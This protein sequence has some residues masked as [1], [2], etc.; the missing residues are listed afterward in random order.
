ML[1]ALRSDPL[2]RMLGHTTVTLV[3][4]TLTYFVLPL[5]FDWSSSWTWVRLAVCLVALTLLGLLM[6]KSIER[7]RR[8]QQVRYRRI[9][10]LLSALYVLVLA[11]ALFY[12]ALASKGG[13]FVGIEDRTD[14]LY[15][16]VTVVSTVGFGDIHASSRFAKLAVTAHM[17]FN[18]VYL[19]TAL[20][21][22]TSNQPHPLPPE[23]GED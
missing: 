4:L 7:S 22:L 8:A 15:F 10:W 1:R 14:A 18:L 6:F 13:Q 3:L 16:S 12:A 17:L 2:V 19:G 5:R 20:R 23:P 21:L 11:F 9:Q